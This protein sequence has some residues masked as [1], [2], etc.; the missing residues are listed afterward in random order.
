MTEYNK[1]F[2]VKKS[3]NVNNKKK[4]SNNSKNNYVKKDSK[5]NYSKKN[6]TNNKKNIKSDNNKKLVKK[7]N[8]TIEKKKQLELTSEIKN[9]KNDLE[10]ELTKEI[11]KKPIDIDKLDDLKEIEVKDNNTDTKELDVNI[12]D[13]VKEESD[14]Y[15]EVEEPV[16]TKKKNVKE[17]KSKRKL[18]KK[19]NRVLKK[20]N[21]VNNRLPL[22]ERI[23]LYAN[24]VIIIGLCI[25]YVGRGL[26]Y[27]DLINNNHYEANYFINYLTNQNNITYN[28]NGLY[29]VDDNNYYYKGFVNN[30]YVN[31]NGRLYRVVSINENS[32]KLIEN[33][34]VT[35]MYYGNNVFG[36]SYINNWLNNDYSNSVISINSD[37]CNK[38]IDIN[39]YKCDETINTKVGLLT[40]EEYLLAGAKESYLN[41][42]NY[43]WLLNYSDKK[44]LYVNNEGNINNT[45]VNNGEYY[46]FGVR[47]VITISR[48]IEL[49]NGVGTLEDPYIIGLEDHAYLN[50][51]NIGS[52][53]KYNDYNFRIIDNNENYTKLILEGYIDENKYTYNQVN[54]KLNEFIKNFDEKYLYKGKFISNQYNNS[55]GYN[56]TN[57][58][59]KSSDNYIGLPSIKDLY[60]LSYKDYWLNNSY[61][62]TFSYTV[63]SNNTLFKDLKSNKN[64]IRPIIYLNNEVIIGSGTGLQNDPLIIEG[65]AKNEL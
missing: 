22:W 36:E 65:G 56:Y 21:S 29:K 54:S 60:I 35:T 14:Y 55:T 20:G 16:I 64:Y 3:N 9:L 33:D 19:F 34:S 25:Y 15:E 48:D 62:G 61:D 8:K 58:T 39:D 28:T 42:K 18:V 49:K 47:P 59:D 30:N 37:Y 40:V 1:N 44:P 13:F 4:N 23:F 63:G 45:V 43:W 50:E 24:Y 52:Y 2:Y 41:N 46:S 12:K 51:H 27:R 31:Y 26:Y 32:I 17:P 7:S 6:Y 11:I 57:K 38:E 53:V 5:N 10:L